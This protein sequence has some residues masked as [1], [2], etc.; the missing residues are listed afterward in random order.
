MRD[1]LGFLPGSACPHYDGEDLRRPRYLQLVEEGFPA[2]YAAE[3]G[4]ALHFAGTE[5]AEA[6]TVRP[7]KRAYRVEPGS[8]MP[9]EARD[10]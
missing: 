9:I 8:E 3:D 2:G 1:G 10:L 7:G 6:V 5:L 4:V